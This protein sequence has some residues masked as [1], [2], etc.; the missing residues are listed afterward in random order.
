MSNRLR[1]VGHILGR[2]SVLFGSL[3][4]RQKSFSQEGEDRVL[5]RYFS[6]RS[7]GFYVDVG[8]HHPFRFSNTALLH[9]RGWRGINID[10][11][12]GSM[13]PFR[14]ARPG[15]VNLEVGVSKEAGE[16]PFFIFN[17]AALNTF[18]PELAESRNQPPYSIERTVQVPL[19]PLRDILAEHV[20]ASQQID[21]M[22][23]D[24]EGRDLEVLESNDWTRY[25]PQMLLVEAVGG[26]WATLA[27]DLAARFAMAQGYAPYAKTVNTLF[28]LRSD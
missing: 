10:A 28:F 21:L 16:A 23:I 14:R 20:A 11:W 7:M 27:D 22:S 1:E 9:R 19:R 15:D 12:P 26:S 17:D 18:D 13:E 25:R 24:V 6:D 2:H 8:A 5:A 4:Y 3:A